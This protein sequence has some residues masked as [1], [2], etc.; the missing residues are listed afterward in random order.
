MQTLSYNEG[1][2]LIEVLL[3]LAIFALVAAS[4]ISLV[5]GGF[6]ALEQGGEQTQ[7]EALAQEG[8]EAVRSIRD[9]AWNENV[10]DT[11]SVVINVSQWEF[12]GEGT[13]ETIDQ[14]TR[15]IDFFDVCRD[16][17]N[18]IVTCPGL[19]NDV[20]SK[21]AVVTVTWEIRPG[22]SNTVRKEAYI[23]NWDTFDWLED[24]LGDFND[25][26]LINTVTSTVYGDGDIVILQ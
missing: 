15:V 7:A 25:G 18:E 9:R 17:S 19:Y 1:Q 24:T 5:V 23:T 10:F 3:A 26:T 2:S 22:V 13:T 4:L 14:F 21:Q 11:S 16:A 8:V 12:L 20:H 6:V